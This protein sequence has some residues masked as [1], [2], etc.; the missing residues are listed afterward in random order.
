MCVF[1]H[2]SSF[3]RTMQMIYTELSLAFSS[4]SSSSFFLYFHYLSFSSSSSSLLTC[5]HF[6]EFIQRWTPDEKIL[7]LPSQKKPSYILFMC[8]KYWH[9]P[10]HNIPEQQSAVFASPSFI[11]H[12]C[13][14][15]FFLSDRICWKEGCGFKS[16]LLC[17]SCPTSLHSPPYRSLMFTVWIN[18]YKTV[19]WEV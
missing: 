13:F 15:V 4:L 7:S 9:Q 12:P 10:W 1:V 18:K 5:L 2:T 17:C 6:G 19:R 14:F 3:R 8:Q 11:I 16:C